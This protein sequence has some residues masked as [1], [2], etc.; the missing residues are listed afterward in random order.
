MRNHSVSSRIY[1]RFSDTRDSKVVENPELP[2]DAIA[3]LCQTEKFQ[4]LVFQIYDAVVPKHSVSL[5]ELRYMIFMRTCMDENIIHSNKRPSPETASEFPG[6][7]VSLLPFILDKVPTPDAKHPEFQLH[8]QAN[9]VL[10]L[11]WAII[12]DLQGQDV[13]LQELTD[14]QYYKFVMAM[15]DYF[16]EYDA[17]ASR[18]VTE[19]LAAARL[20]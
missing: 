4:E 5:Q 3:K 8:K 1:K 13:Q 19:M 18:Q 15:H 20:E 11:F 7:P 6:V 14:L 16:I 17:F 9:N 12:H 10:G 2:V